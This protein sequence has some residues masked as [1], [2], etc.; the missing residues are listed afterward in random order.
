MCSASRL[1]TSVIVLLVILT[2]C[3]SATT[4][5]PPTEVPAPSPVS[6]TASPMFTAAP[7]STTTPATTATL[8]AQDLAAELDTALQ[9][10]VE[11]GYLS[12]SVL[13]A[14]D[15][16]I[17]L[18]QGYGLADRDKKIPNAAQTRYRIGSVTKQFTAMAILMLQ[19]QGKINV[20]DPICDYLTDCPMAWKG[21]A[22]HHLL[23]HT[24]GI[25]GFTELAG[26]E[27][28]KATPSSPDQ[29]I[30][31]FRDRPLDFPP[32]EKWSYSNSNYVLLGKIIERASGQPYEDFLRTNIFEP[33]GMINTGYDHDQ[34]DLAIGYANEITTT[35]DYLDMTIPYAAGSLYS[36]IEDLY[37][38]DQALYTEQL[39]PQEALDA[40]FTAYATIPTSGG[41][42]YGYGWMI[43]QRFNRRII[44]HGGGIDGY[45]SVIVRYP[46]DK[47]TVIVLTN[48]QNL[49]PTATSE[50]LATVVFRER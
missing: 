38:W 21:I 36:T 43:G 9:R 46:D 6:A 7:E 41:M 44:F 26:Y 23:T 42:G 8:T 16:Q 32:G 15:G 5:A 20:Q 33:L 31:R 11:A 47:V 28:T 24:S 19:E 30:L 37:R 45:T 14:R 22:L 2:A 39:V 35:A 3:N 27:T 49:D 18:S 50:V 48:Q 4:P 17:I 29:T 1:R 10:V 25:P 34:S 13:V 12:G 40:M